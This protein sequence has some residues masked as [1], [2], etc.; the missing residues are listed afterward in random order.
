MKARIVAT[1]VTLMAVVIGQPIADAE[2]FYGFD[3]GTFEGW[4]YIEPDGTEFQVGIA[5]N[6]WVPSTEMIDIGDGFTLVPATSGDFRVV[7]FPWDTRDCLGGQQ[8]ETQILRSPEFHLDGSGDI[9]IDMIGG[10]LRGGTTAAIEED[11]PSEVSDLP[12]F[13]TADEG[14]HASQGFAL[15]DAAS[16]EYLLFG[17]SDVEND[18]KMRASDPPSRGQWQTV[19]ISQED[20]APFANDGQVYTV[21]IYDS[22]LGGWGWIGYDSVRIPGTLAT[23]N[24]FPGD[25]DNNGIADTDDLDALVGAV[26]AG[27]N[28]SEFDLTGDDVVNSDDIDQWLSDA[29]TE[30]GFA[31]PYQ[32][33][34][35]NLDGTVDAI[36]LNAMALNWQT[37]VSTWIQGDFTADGLV[38]AADLNRLALNWQ[39]TIPTAAVVPEPS[40]FVLLISGFFVLILKRR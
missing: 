11:F 2:L 35:A 3:D 26:A 30:N 21:D 5:T 8:C 9:S 14:V 12:E 6:G 37:R 29:A 4:Q 36:D 1:F 18:G 16:D 39:Q 17:F 13:R 19:S 25:F 32:F 27:E 38:D 20:L 10:Q 34:D 33:G 7:P 22:Y 15:R 31:A 23:G 40:V 28:P 24:G